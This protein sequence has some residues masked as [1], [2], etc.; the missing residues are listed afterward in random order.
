MLSFSGT[1]YSTVSSVVPV[2][3]RVVLEWWR[4]TPDLV[5]GGMKKDGD[6]LWSRSAISYSKYK[7]L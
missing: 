3:L 7:K 1:S 4:D 5:D 2:T 6:Q